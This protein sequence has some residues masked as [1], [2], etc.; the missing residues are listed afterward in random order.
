MLFCNQCK[1]T[2][3]GGFKYCPL[4]Q[5]ELQGTADANDD[6]F[7]VI[8]QIIKPFK[9]IVRFSLF[10]T[11]VVSVISV[12]IDLAL[13]SSTRLGWSLFII[14]GLASLWMSFGIANRRWWNIPKIIIWLLIFTSVLEVVW[15]YLTGFYKWSFTFVIPI[16]FSASIVAL[17]VFAI[18]RKLQPGDYLFILFIISIVSI[19][20][21]FLI[22]FNLVSVIYPALICFVFSVISASRLI[23]F[24]RKSLLKEFKWRM[25]L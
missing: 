13:Q 8:P 10:L 3:K 22:I 5:G 1:I 21:L 4:C 16:M 12:A 17:S 6:A 18:I 25:H 14:A 19:C 2:V 11:I 20:S 15:D 23:I 9:R 7:P 24:E